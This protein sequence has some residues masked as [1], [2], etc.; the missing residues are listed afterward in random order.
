MS[1]TRNI[2]VLGTSFAGLSISHYICKH[3]LPKLKQSKDSNYVLHLVDQSTHFWWHIAAPREIVSVKDMPHSKC[4]VPTM[5]GFKQYADLQDSIVF[6]HGT[7]AGL[8]TNAR[9][10]E[11]NKAQG[12]DERLEYYALIIATGIR[13]PTPLTTMHGNYTVTQKALD[14]MN[15]KL[16][17]AKDI[18]I[19]GG[20]PVGVETAG[21]IGTHYAGQGKKIT[22]IAGSDKLL[23]ILRKSYADKAQK[24]LEKVGV[25][26]VYNVKTVGSQQTAD[27]RTEIKL[28]NG[29]TMVA[30]AFIPGYGVTPN[31]E[32]LPAE[33]RNP[34]TKYVACN[35]QT[36]R[37]DVAG[38]RVYAA[39]DVSGA[40][41]GGVLKLY[42]SIPVLGANLSHDLLSEAKVGGVPA[43]KKYQRK[44]DETQLVP[45]GIKTGLGAFNGWS[46]P[47]FVISMVKGKHYFA[48]TIDDIWQGKKFVKA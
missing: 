11:I 38:P 34:Q 17:S 48:N 5:E 18:V 39:G 25:T 14:E 29:E 4:F 6:H 42:G 36:M 46:M 37:V 15:V 2:V 21:E 35:G 45:I 41:T 10:V 22:L 16:A 12:G 3:I 7:A 40:D 33:L 26:V 24:M 27:G 30:D 31:T 47:G 32:F 44:D 9:F 8:D 1:E 28:D 23:P 20:G 43:E 19:A 13:S